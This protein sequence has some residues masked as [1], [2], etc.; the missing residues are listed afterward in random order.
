LQNPPFSHA[1]RAYAVDEYYKTQSSRDELLENALRLQDRYGEGDWYCNPSEPEIIKHLSEKVY[2][3]KN[4]G[5]REDG[6]RELGS[7]L[8]KQGDGR[9]RLYVHSRCGNLLHEMLV[10]DPEK[11]QFDHAIDALRYAVMGGKPNTEPIQ[12]LFAKRP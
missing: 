10:Y 3:R 9:C 1:R 12:I 2:A 4:E 6:I 11:K 5:K 7:R 8:V